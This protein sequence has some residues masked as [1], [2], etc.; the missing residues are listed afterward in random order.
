MAED[1]GPAATALHAVAPEDP[2]V[3][4]GGGPGRRLGAVRGHGRH[5][6]VGRAKAQPKQS[7]PRL[8]SEQLATYA[9]TWPSFVAYGPPAVALWA[10]INRGHQPRGSS[11]SPIATACLILV[12]VPQKSC[13]AT[14]F[15]SSG[16][17]AVS[18]EVRR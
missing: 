7:C 4:G 13:R 1:P 10:A 6:A 2:I 9:L 8:V 5:L 16:G 12:H 15:D 18:I 17:G 14:Y 11:A 3:A